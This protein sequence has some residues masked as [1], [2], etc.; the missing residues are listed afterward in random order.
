VIVTPTRVR[1]TV[2]ANWAFE[3]VM[4]VLLVGFCVAMLSPSHWLRAVTIVAAAVVLA[5]VLR[6]VLPPARARL[7]CIRSRFFDVVCFL[8]CGGLVLGFGAAVPR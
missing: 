3:S 4:V 1:Q 2:A 7:L 5:G 8:A 6:A